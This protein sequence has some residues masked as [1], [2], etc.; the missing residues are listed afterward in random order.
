MFNKIFKKKKKRY[1]GIYSELLSN[2]FTIFKSENEK[3]GV[4]DK[5]LKILIPAQYES[6]KFEPL[7]NW[8]LGVNFYKDLEN[9]N[10]SYFFHTLDGKL[11][12]KLEDYEKINIDAYGNIIIANR[13]GKGVLDDKLNQIFPPKYKD[14]SSIDSSL[15]K[16]KKDIKFGIIGKEKR[17]VYDFTISK[18]YGNFKNGFLIIEEEQSFFQIDKNG[19]KIKSFEYTHL[20]Y[21][22]SNTYKAPNKEDRNKFKAVIGGVKINEGIEIDEMFNYRGKWGIIDIGGE[23]IIKPSYDYIDFLRDFNYYKIGLGQIKFECSSEGKWIAKGGKWGIIDDKNETIIPAK[24][25][26]VEEIEKD[27]FAVNM[28]GTVYFNDE[29]QENYWT[30]KGGKWGVLKRGNKQIVPIEYDN[31]MLS[32][33]KVK[34]YIFVQKNSP[35]FNGQLEYDVFDFD[36]NKIER[37]KPN[38]KNYM[39]S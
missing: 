37:D 5:E 15:F 20:F 14:F 32:W 27:L 31:I 19:K 6:I 26:W 36:G 22:R 10:W 34:D 23:E 12:S 17:I 3:W 39:K 24:F 21:A 1:N 4:L 28:D 8:F 13:E 11:F 7:K 2:G 29:P 16:A 33:F 30:V 38:Y 25:D 9:K 35:K 18:I